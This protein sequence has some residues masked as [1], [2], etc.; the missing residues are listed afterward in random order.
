VSGR[1]RTVRRTT[2]V[3]AGPD[4]LWAWVT[5]FTNI[6]HEMWPV[7]RMHVPRRL[8][9]MTIADVQPGQRLG[10]I[11][12]LYAGFL[13]LDHDDLRLL[14]IE[15]GRFLERSTMGSMALWQHERTVTAIG[16]GRSRLSDVLTF[17][18]RLALRPLAPVLERV[19]GWLFSHRQRRVA[20]AFASR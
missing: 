9:G 4:L 6:N 8:R 15:P 19:V 17:R 7:M 18:P 20:A 14:E 16:G 5:D 2:V 11:P 12:I 10:R 3:S 13:P 1:E